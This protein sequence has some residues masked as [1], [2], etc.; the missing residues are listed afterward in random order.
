VTGARNNVAI[1]GPGLIQR[2]RMHG[3]Q[4]IGSTNARIENVTMS[5]NCAAGII[6]QGNA[7]GT[8]VEG[9]TSVRNGSTAP[10]LSCGGI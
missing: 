10:G 7:F 6:I 3:V 4:V 8:L 2:F 9:N 1:R 5:S